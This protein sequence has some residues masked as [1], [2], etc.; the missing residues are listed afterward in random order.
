MS[1]PFHVPI[2]PS[3]FPI[4]TL[5]IPGSDLVRASTIL[6]GKVTATKKNKPLF[7]LLKRK[8]LS[9]NPLPLPVFL[10]GQ[11]IKVTA[12]SFLVFMLFLKALALIISNVR[13]ISLFLTVCQDFFGFF[14][15]IF[16]DCQSILYF[17]SQYLRHY[18]VDNVTLGDYDTRY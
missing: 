11:C 5:P 13:Y 9:R 16:A 2:P 10:S 14:F 18:A 1:F 4:F 17:F 7:C 15:T 12:Y 8:K 6:A 3:R